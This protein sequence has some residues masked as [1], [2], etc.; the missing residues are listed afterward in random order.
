MLDAG[1]VAG[2]AAPGI[3]AVV[4]ANAYGHGA[5]AVGRALES[6]GASML[7]C[8][9]IEEGVALRDGGVT[10]PIL[11]F[12]AL[13]VSDVDGVFTHRLT[14]TV[15]T[16]GAARALES[17]AAAKNVRLACHLKIDTGMNRLG[18]RHDNL[19]R[20]LPAVL[21]SPHLSFDAIYTHFA[22]AD[23]ARV[24]R[25]WTSSARDSR[26]RRPRSARWACAT[27]RA[28]RQTPPRSCA[29]RARWYDWVRPGLLLYGIV[30]PPLSAADLG[31]VSCPVTHVPYRRGERP[32]SRRGRGLR[33]AVDGWMSR[34]RSRSCPPVTPT[35]STP[36]PPGR[37]SVLIRG[38]RAPIVGS[39]CMDMIT[40]DVT[41]RDVSPGDDV[42]L[43]GRQ[44][45]EEIT[46]REIAADDWVDYVGSAV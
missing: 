25:S 33:I 41:G 37:T 1:R 5:V 42:V 23:R 29:T 8:A 26:S 7:A 9:D 10:I 2:R 20:T 31:A 3:I 16:P 21:Q 32:A 22:T 18:F 45:D 6:A 34:G 46:A 19:R 39:V 12:G 27:A 14:P 35:V 36:A 4:K 43:I 11:V 38:R 30:P 24:R 17:A 44:D 15:S 40:V 13:S 28:T